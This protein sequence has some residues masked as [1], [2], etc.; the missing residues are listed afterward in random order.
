MIE[1]QEKLL[2]HFL[3]RL[4]SEPMKE[5]VY[6]IEEIFEM[7]KRQYDFISLLTLRIQKNSI[8]NFEMII[9]TTVV[10]SDEWLFWH[11]HGVQILLSMV[12][13]KR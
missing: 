5:M 12:H 13:L 4:E 9:K 8:N 10:Q 6:M 7:G 2:P 11:D 1:H 3:F